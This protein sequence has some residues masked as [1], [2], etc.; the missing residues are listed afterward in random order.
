MKT[1]FVMMVMMPMMM[2]T[3]MY[4][5]MRMMMMITLRMAFKDVVFTDKL[6]CS[7]I[8]CAF[9]EVEIAVFVIII[10]C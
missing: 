6:Q 3:M 4:T 5:F 1:I 2:M 7:M 9:N 10:F 8:I